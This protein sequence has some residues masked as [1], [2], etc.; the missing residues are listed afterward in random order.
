MT[1]KIANNEVEAINLILLLYIIKGIRKSF[2]VISYLK[3]KPWHCQVKSQECIHL[4]AYV[5]L[6]LC[7]RALQ[8][9]QT[10]SEGERIVFLLPPNLRD[11]EPLG[12][13]G[14]GIEF[15]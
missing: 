5:S 2:D 12:V 9:L 13:R 7:F 14:C 6:Y 15:N 8:R 10:S 11:R 3:R 4:H 1:E